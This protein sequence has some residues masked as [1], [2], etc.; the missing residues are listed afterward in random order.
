MSAFLFIFKQFVV[1][2]CCWVTVG[3]LHV[4]VVFLG[5]SRDRADCVLWPSEEAEH[6]SWYQ[7][8]VPGRML[9]TWSIYGK[10]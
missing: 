3:G 10:S 8:T 7:E 2:V 1:N 6:P 4:C 5:Y 9:P